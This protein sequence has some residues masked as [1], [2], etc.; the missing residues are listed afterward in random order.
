MG[1]GGWW[2]KTFIH[3]SP[4]T[5]PLNMKTFIDKIKS[6]LHLSESEMSSVLKVMMSGQTPAEQ[7][8]AFLLALRDKGYSVE[9]ITGAART[10][11][12]FS[13]KVKACGPIVLDTCGTGGDKK[14]TFNISTV[15]AIIAAGAG[16]MTAKHGN[17]S[18]SSR[19]GSADVLEALGVKIDLNPKQ[20]ESC[21][22]EAGIVF[23]FAPLFHPAMKH[24]APVRKKIGVSIFN[25]MGP[26]VNPAG[27]THQIVGVYDEKYMDSMIHVLK[28]LGSRRALVVYAKDGLDEISTTTSTLISE[29]DGSQIRRYDIHPEDFG[30]APARPEDLLG[31]DLD[32]NVGI[33]EDILEKKQTGARRDIVVFNAA[34]ALWLTGKT[35]TVQ[36]GISLAKDLIDS[37]KAHEKL[38]EWIDVSQ[39]YGKM[40]L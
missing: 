25:I 2:L 35:P 38:D 20:A 31:G 16:V 19:C 11:R 39:R 24:V 33:V 21:L 17:R 23:L 18:I 34:Y 10:M 22:E 1:N 36:E 13:L 12:E 9:E 4:T 40:Q 27:A 29:W 37:G 30:I 32:T 26:L 15:V 28:N 3:H 5:I 7:I 8:E 6:G 14:G